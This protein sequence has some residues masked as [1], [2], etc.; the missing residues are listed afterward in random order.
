MAPVLI[1]PDVHDRTERVE[2][3][4]E[5]ER[6]EQAV[7]LGDWF[8]SGPGDGPERARRTAE[9][10]RKVAGDRR[11]VLLLGNH[12][13]HYLWPRLEE[14]RGSGYTPEK[15]KAIAEALG[16]AA[17]ARRMFRLY[18]VAGGWLVSHA[19][20]DARLA[21]PEWRGDVARLDAWLE[22]HAQRTLRML[23]EG[24]VGALAGPGSDR[25]GTQEV[26]GILWCDFESLTPLSGVRQIVGHSP[27]LEVRRKGAADC[28]CVCLDTGLRH[29]GVIE[30]GRLRVV[31]I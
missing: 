23:D 7:F 11:H 5:R 4:L 22:Q 2:E 9:Y 24:F 28:E 15:Q 20:L 30:G 10:V 29:Y 3:I 18:A 26:G 12:E 25:G 1:I 13:Q 17:E 6:Y 19:G 21:P 8:D 31:E 27:G 16:P 14:I